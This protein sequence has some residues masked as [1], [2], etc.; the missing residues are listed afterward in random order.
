VLAL[1]SSEAGATLG[2]AID[3]LDREGIPDQEIQP[4]QLKKVFK[5]A[6][7]DLDSI[8]SSVGDAGF[9]LEG[10]SESSLGAAAVLIA[11]GNSGQEIVSEV[12][13]FL[14][15]AGTEGVTAIDGK[16]SGFSISNT[17]LG[18]KPLVVVASGV[19]I[20]VSYGL[21]AATRYFETNELKDDPL[22]KEATVSFSPVPISG[23]ARGPA[24]LRLALNLVS[25]DDRKGLL[26][27]K[28]YLSKID[29]LALGSESSGDLAKAK[30]IVGVGK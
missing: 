11:T 3:R 9:F 4:G 12:E 26:E 20:V 8:A 19:H 21:R 23:F 7:L 27:A 30:V 17:D 24:A 1:T 2:K 6:G 29:Y 16:F 10:E 5:E 28:P 15:S 22:F 13:G 25:A 18:R 14:R